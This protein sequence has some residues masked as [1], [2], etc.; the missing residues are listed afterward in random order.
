M[1]EPQSQEVHNQTNKYIIP[2]KDKKTKTNMIKNKKMLQPFNKRVPQI[3]SALLV[4]IC[5]DKLF[6]VTVLDRAALSPFIIIIECY[7]D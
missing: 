5:L 3:N 1:Q 6:G 4:N 2:S 7:W